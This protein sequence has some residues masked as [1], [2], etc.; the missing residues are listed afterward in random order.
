META[1]DY[2]CE[3]RESVPCEWDSQIDAP[4]HADV[5]EK[6]SST[7]F[8]CLTASL[9][10]RQR[11]EPPAWTGFPTP[12][13]GWAHIVLP[14]IVGH[15]AGFEEK[16]YEPSEW[17]RRERFY[18]G[19]AD[20]YSNNFLIIDEPKTRDYWGGRHL[21]RKDYN[22]AFASASRC[23]RRLV[24]RGLVGKP[25][26]KR[27][28]SLTKAGIEYAREMTG[29]EPLP[30]GWDLYSVT[31]GED[32]KFGLKFEPEDAYWLSDTDAE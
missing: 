23:V 16:K 29:R 17:G 26:Q 8:S 3:V 21:K 7:R 12:S 22:A 32:G 15:I 28:I 30:R 5:F 20:E 2:Y 11:V 31:P 27:K 6:I 24:E 4:D 14:Q 1:Y 18:G 10:Q 25:Y 9:K 13:P 19:Y